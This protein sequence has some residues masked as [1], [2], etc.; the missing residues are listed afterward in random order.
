MGHTV[1]WDGISFRRTARTGAASTWEG[2]VSA[3]AASVK[4]VERLY[5]GMH[6]AMARAVDWRGSS[7]S[8][9]AACG[10]G[11]DWRFHIGRADR[12]CNILTL[13]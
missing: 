11:R 1:F 7:G 9:K 6:A 4:A 12:A 13:P 2:T 3:P 8:L 10:R 5:K